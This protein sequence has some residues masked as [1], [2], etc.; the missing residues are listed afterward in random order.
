[1]EKLFTSISKYAPVSHALK[2]ALRKRLKPYTFSKK[3]LIHD[4]HR[5]CRRSYF[6]EE[7]LIRVYYLKDGVEISEFFCCENEWINSPRSF[8][9][10]KPDIYY[11]DT[12]EPSKVLS[13]ELN[14]LMY[15]FDH[16]NAMEKYARMDMGGSF[17][18][19]IDRLHVL[20]FTSPKEKYEH[21]LQSYKDIHHRIPLGM[22]ASYLGIA[23]ET[24]SRIR[25]KA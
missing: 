22:I 19:L 20:R 8:I 2:E 6:I 16:F 7:G 23:Q 15:L 13:L 18:H 1:M 9:Q 10:Q 25:R 24:L 4:A 21:F 12:I 5:V 17:L 3:T 11:I 14:D